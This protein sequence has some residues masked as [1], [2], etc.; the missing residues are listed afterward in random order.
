M[1]QSKSGSNTEQVMAVLQE[2]TQPAPLPPSLAASKD[3]PSLVDEP[4]PTLEPAG[5]IELFGTMPPWDSELKLARQVL[6]GAPTNCT[7]LEVASYFWAVGDGSYGETLKPYVV[8]WPKR[9]NPVIVEFFKATRT[10]PEGDS[11]PWCAALIN[12]CLVRG[13]IGRTL[14]MSSSAPTKNAS[15]KSFLDWGQP[16]TMPRP[17]DIVVFDNYVSGGGH[18]AFFL[19][20][21]GAIWRAAQAI[22][23][24]KV[25]RQ[26]A[27]KQ[28]RERA[29]TAR[30]PHRSSASAGVVRD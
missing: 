6:S 1:T 4:L 8:A 25:V 26:N 5:N 10:K 17:G 23:L 15:A 12:Y 19:A 3:D 18:V 14:P 27:K 28:E 7:P 16:T 30:I 2:D 13:A 20:D 24:Q 9:W 22:H 11:T 21:Q 29:K